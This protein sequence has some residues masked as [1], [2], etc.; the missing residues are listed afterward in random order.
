MR[1]CIDINSDK[2]CAL[3]MALR[4]VELDSSTRGGEVRFM[5]NA[6]LEQLLSAALGALWNGRLGGYLERAEA[7]V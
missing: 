1:N 3:H 4:L 6:A 7:I 5:T 2:A